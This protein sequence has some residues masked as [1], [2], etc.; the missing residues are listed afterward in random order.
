[1]DSRSPF[2]STLLFVLLL[3]LPVFANASSRL[4]IVYMGEK[5]HD[6]PSVVTASHHDALTSVF[7]S[8]DEAMKSIVYSYKHGFS[9]FAAMLTESQADELAKLP[10]VI[11]VKPNTYHETH[12]TRSWDFLGLN[13]NEQSSLLKKAGYGEDVIVGVDTGI[14]PESQSFDDNSYGPVPARW[15]GKCQTG[16]AFNTTGCNRKIIGA[17]WYSSGVPDESLKGDY[18]SPRDL[19][20][21]G[22]HTASTIA[23]KQVWNASHHRSG[24]AAGVA[25]GGAP[26][27]RLA[28]YKACWGTAG[29]CSAAAVLAAVDDAIN[30]GVD[31]LSLSLGIGSDIP[32]TLHAVASGMT[33]VFA[34]G[35][36][37]PA[38]QTVENV[39][40]WVI[41]VAA[42]TIDRSFPTVVSLGNKEKLVGQSLNFNATKNNS[43]YHMLVF[44]SSCDEE[45]LATVN[46]TGKI[47]L[48]YVPL[49]AAATS[50]PNPAFGTAAIGIAK[51]GAKGLIFAHQRTNV[52]DDLEN[53]NKILPAGCMMVDFEIAARIASYLN[54]TRKPVAKISRAVTVVGNGVLAP[55]IAAFSS[56][57]P[58]IDFPGILKPDVAAPGVS[59]LAAVGDSY[60][61]MSGTSMA[62]P[63]VSAVAALLKSVHP[64]WSPAMIKS[65][66]ITTGTYSRHNNTMTHRTQHR[67]AA[68]T[69]TACTPIYNLELP[70]PARCHDD[71]D[72]AVERREAMNVDSKASYLI[73]IKNPEQPP[74]SDGH[75]GEY[76]S[77]RDLSGH[78]T[79]TAS[80]IVGGQ[81]WNVSHRQ[82]GLAAGMARG[83]APRARLAVYKACWGDSNSTCGDASVLAAIDDAINDGVDVL[84]LS[85]GGYGEVAG[86]LHAVAR[87]ITVVFA[88]GNE[89]P[90]P[91]SV[92]NAVPWVITVAA[93]TIDRS[94][95]T[96]ISLGNKEK[97]VGQSLNYNA[98]MNSSNFHMLVDGQRC[99][100]DSLASVNITGKIVLCSAP[101]EAA[102]SS[103]NSSFAAT[104][105]AVVKRRAKGLIY[106]QYSANVLVGFEDFCHLYLPAS[107]VLVDYEIASRIAS[108][109]KSTRKS[110]VK[111][112]RVVSV[113]GNGVLAP[114]IA[115][116]SSRG[117]SNE[118]PV[119]LKPDISAPGVSI[120]A[121]VGDSYKFMSGTSMACPHVSAVAALL[122]SVHPDW[123]PAM[124]KS[125]IVTTGMYSCHTTSSVYIPY[126]ASVT[127]RFGMPIQAEGAPRKIA[128]PFDFGGGQ[129]DP[130]KS[131]DPGLVYD[132]DPKEYT[133][134]FNC[135][136]GPKDDC[137]S[138]VGQLY[139]LNLP[140]IAVPDLKD[141][142]TVWRTVTNVGGE[143]GTYKAS[144]EA[145]AGVRMS[146]EPSIITFT[147]GGSRSATF[148]VTFTARQRVQAGYT[149]GS[150]TW[151]DGVTHSVRIPVVVRTII[152][153]FVSDTS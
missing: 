124:I 114:R 67:L 116:F 69:A 134:F 137:E 19:N 11:T 36:A 135:T 92:S 153:D 107:C 130:D 125:A 72:A 46:V 74:S 80:T 5:K 2:P 47:V 88:G 84:S 131:I 20:G 71:A 44:G 18:M 27:A 79:H 90:V 52:F 148:K 118:F 141:S 56:R 151:L 126:M 41:T 115:M 17:R 102:N 59:I 122:K 145:P 95:P 129:I 51:G 139:Q 132:I 29:T 45:S 21:H 146:V 149:F 121:A 3:V 138:Y 7:G 78:G 30:D 85:L 73:Q 23:G 53:C 55:R 50:S 94:F 128:D 4:Y 48:C 111:I 39:V 97:L 6:D 58:S 49:E 82:S 60:K 93:S 40:P 133:K 140:S 99:D 110:V 106:A 152:Q 24:L 103:P 15:K 117:P 1:M 68:S 28:V 104:F 86:T 35:N 136:L 14:W 75:G 108:Y 109:A 127:D 77:P 31:V 112:S 62:C 34:G 8:K 87:G 43:N 33:V 143:E 12:T 120:L 70:S 119:I 22:T 66:I 61:F 142:V 10:G 144:I 105:V 13:Y 89:G 96:V 81:V 9:G 32:G 64:D 150:L 42:T 100:E 38:P 57:G 25:R 54:S 147:R 37:G 123:S 26:R 65:A 83:G 76:M 113:V 16:V 98:T 91:Q 63:H 101:L